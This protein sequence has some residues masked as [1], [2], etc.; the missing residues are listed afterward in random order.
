MS[1]LV[2]GDVIISIRS[3]NSCNINKNV[4]SRPIGLVV[5]M[6]VFDAATS[7]TKFRKEKYDYIHLIA[8]AIAYFGTIGWNILGMNAHDP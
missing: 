6:A 3:W 7:G 2:I 4:P 5:L 1:L 8:I